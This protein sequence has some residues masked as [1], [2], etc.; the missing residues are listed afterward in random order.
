VLSG[1]SCVIWRWVPRADG[2]KADKVP[3][4][5]HAPERH[6]STQNPATWGSFALCMKLVE[7]GCADGVGKVVRDDPDHIYLDLD[8]CR[9]PATGEMTGWAIRVVEEA[10][11]YTEITPSGT[12]VRIIGKPGFLRGP[13]Q[14]RVH[15]PDGGSIEIFFRCVR[16]L[17]VSFDLLPGAPERLGD[18]GDLA[19]DLLAIAGPMPVGD[20]VSSSDAA[21]SI[22]D[23]ASALAQIPNGDVPWET[24]NEIGMAVQ[25]ASGG[26]DAGLEAFRAWSAKSG[27]H[28]DA[29]C[30][31]R[32]RHWFRSPASRLGFGKLFYLASTVNPLWQ[33]SSRR[34][35]LSGN[36]APLAALAP[37]GEPW[38][39]EAMRPAPAPASA[40]PGR[41]IGKLR[42]R[43]VDDLA[44]APPRAY[45]V[46]GLLAPKELSVWWGA[47]KCGKTFVC[48]RVAFAAALGAEV[49][50][51]A[52]ARPLRVLYV[53][54]EGEG[55][56]GNRL[57]AL[58]AE[59][60]DPGD[61]L[62]VIAQRAQ[63]GPPGEHLEDLIMAAREHR[64][65]IVVIDTLARTFGTG[66]E[67]SAQDMGGFIAACD[68]LREEGRMPGGTG[69]HVMVIHHGAKDPAA[70]TPRGSGALLGAAD[71]V[72][73]ITKP[74]GDAP[75]QA[76]V[77]HAKDD[78]DG[79]ALPFRL[80]VVKL[81]GEK[82]R[83][84][85]IADLETEGAAGARGWEQNRP[86]LANQEARALAL[87]NDAIASGGNKLPGGKLFPAHPDL[88]C[89]PFEEWRRICRER[90]LSAK[91]EKRA[92]N[93]A[94]QRAAEGLLA[95]RYVATAEH[96]GQKLVWVAK[97][98]GT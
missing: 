86:K 7:E 71:L 57:A 88:R 55:G 12:G 31:E 27:K 34:P 45:L 18:I 44:D 97:G 47:P 56:I 39:G 59:L 64:A 96:D 29:A 40:A 32:W 90:S 49:W 26:S 68:R 37:Q 77:E 89:I 3:F 28:S 58:R 30:D 62:A 93:L 2:G 78:E 13:I 22:E 87:L 65:D 38:E 60:G 4:N 76:M 50:G 5:P 43:S 98:A 10:D 25:R 63:I 1:N 53:A 54:A 82:E 67:D 16:Y 17:T 9:D 84:T 80:R 81:P 11:S 92:E 73:K 19:A 41:L 69:P 75:G 6:A 61:R 42:V 74:K 23:I 52:T 83:I 24:W 21:A 8:K 72:V 51:R 95:G 70:Q 91:G 48:L 85:C 94:F 36:A 15:M 79:T 35:A 46:A 33:P 66:N 20:A 14:R